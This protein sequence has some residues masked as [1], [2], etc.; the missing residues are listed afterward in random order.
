MGFTIGG[1]APSGHVPRGNGT[2]YVDGQVGAADLSLPTP[3][4]YKVTGVSFTT[5][6]TTTIFTVPSGSTFICTAAY[7]LITTV[8]RLQ[9]DNARYLAN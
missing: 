9:L 4:V 3:V 7:A 5:T 6:G 1:A 2:N 8:Y